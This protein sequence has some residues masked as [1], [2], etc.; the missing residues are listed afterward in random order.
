M[1]I[2]TISN[3][4]VHY[5]SR[6]QRDETVRVIDD[7]NLTIDEGET[8][9]LVGESGSGKSTLAHAIVGLVPAAEGSIR[10]QGTEL[11]GLS[12]RQRRPIQS[13]LQIVF[14]N[15]LLSLSPRFR[16]GAQLHEALNV[17]TSLDVS[18]RQ[19]R[20]DSTMAELELSD[21][22]LDRFPHE[23]SGGQAQR[24]V[25][26]RA[27]VL[28]PAVILFDEPTSALDVSVQAGVLNL[29]GRLKR[30]RK[31]T[32]LFITHDLS[33]ARHLCDRI[34]VLQNGEIAE[35]AT[36]ADLFANPQHDYTRQL[37]ASSPTL[38]EPFQ[39]T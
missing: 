28:D 23:L 16:I 6:E 2:L 27:L 29:L 7:L 30:E 12:R 14:Q 18:Q 11:T 32:Y 20:I 36:T 34:A 35:L 15:P 39:E 19:Q 37:L 8:L 38:G 3:L 1:T 26:A 31:L 4:S 10:F 25:L 24:V 5:R 17:H 33:V 22:M 13:E 21:A 9:G